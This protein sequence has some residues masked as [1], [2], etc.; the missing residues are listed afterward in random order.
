MASMNSKER[1][2]EYLDRLKAA[3]DIRSEAQKIA[4]EIDS[5]VW[6]KDQKKLTREEKLQILNELEQL[7]IHRE[8]DSRG[9][10]IVEASDN[11]G[12][13]DVISALKKGIKD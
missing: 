7:A 4:N 8:K 9:Y 1:A 3:A 5:L 2:R 11:S 6:L 10:I 12:V 13:I